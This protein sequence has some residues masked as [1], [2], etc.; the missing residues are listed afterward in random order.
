[1]V[2][3][4]LL[5]QNSRRF[6]SLN[7]LP[8]EV[9]I[10]C[11]WHGGWPPSQCPISGVHLRVPPC[12]RCPLQCCPT[13]VG[14]P[15]PPYIKCLYH[16]TPVG[17]PLHEMSPHQSATLH[18]VSPSQMNDAGHHLI[19]KAEDIKWQK[20]Y[21]RRQLLVKGTFAAKAAFSYLR[22]YYFFYFFFLPFNYASSLW[23]LT[24]CCYRLLLNTD[25][26]VVL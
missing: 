12:I 23:R 8:E 17:V 11:L 10:S 4:R 9:W 7:Y 13:S 1:M 6:C 26:C 25:F 22:G 24:S 20:K 21:C 18:Q 2:F 16:H 19:W 5:N 15:K 3:K 14:P